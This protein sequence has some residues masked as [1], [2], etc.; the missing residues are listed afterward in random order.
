MWGVEG[1]GCHAKAWIFTQQDPIGLAGGLNLY[2]FA[3][4][5]PVNF[6][7]PFGLMACPPCDP[8]GHGVMVNVI[9]QVAQGQ[10]EPELTVG[11][12]PDWISPSGIWGAGRRLFSAARGV[13]AGRAAAGGAYEAAKAGGRHAGLLENYAGRN[14]REVA[15][16]ARSLERRAAAHMDK[17][18]DPAK[19]V[20]NWSSLDPRHQQAIVQGWRDEAAL[21]REQAEVLRGLLQ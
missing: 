19:H 5:D 18:A 21:Y 10:A 3:N 13:F 6:S 12:F 4:G 1:Y 15:R 7:D 20:E 17:V 8:A 11:A 2:G 9:G 16:G 14:A